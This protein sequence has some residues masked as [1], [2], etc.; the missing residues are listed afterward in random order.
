MQDSFFNQQL[1]TFHANKTE[2]LQGTD[3]V[4][5]KLILCNLVSFYAS[6]SFITVLTRY[7]PASYPETVEYSPHS[8]CYLFKIHFNIIQPSTSK[9]CNCFL[10]PSGLQL[11]LNKIHFS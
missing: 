3:F 7:G 8:P 11:K 9:S 6:Q 1:S 5:K 2:Y 10:F 4:L